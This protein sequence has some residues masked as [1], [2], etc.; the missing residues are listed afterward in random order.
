[1]GTVS[2]TTSG[3][4]LL[5]QA[6][7]STTGSTGSSSDTQNLTS[8][9]ESASPT[10]VVELSTA[11]LELQVTDGLFGVSAPSN[12][13]DGLLTAAYTPHLPATVATAAQ[14]AS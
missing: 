8:F 12:I 13:L 1:M 7:T 11:A 2:S 3:L 10:D 14:P 9:L 5:A 6:L 4:A